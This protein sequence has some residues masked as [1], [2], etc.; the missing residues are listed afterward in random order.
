MFAH[1]P[2]VSLCS[3]RSVDSACE[4]CAVGSYTLESGQSTCLQC[5]LQGELGIR[6]SNGNATVDRGYWPYRDPGTGRVLAFQVCRKLSPAS[7]PCP[8]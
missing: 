4:V 2:C 1:V 3:Q 6:C 7:V 8:D 5:T